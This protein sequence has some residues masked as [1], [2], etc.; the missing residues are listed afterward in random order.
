MPTDWPQCGNDQIGYVGV[1]PNQTKFTHPQPIRQVRQGETNPALLYLYF[2]VVMID[3]ITPAL[4]EVGG[5]PQINLF[6]SGWTTVD[7]GQLESLDF[8]NY[9]CSLSPACVANGLGIILGQYQGL[10]TLQA[11]A[12]PIE[13][14]ESYRESNIFN[15]G[16]SP[17]LLSYVTLAEAENYFATRMHTKYWD[18]ACLQDKLKSLTTATK[19]IDRLAFQG[20]KTS[21]YRMRIREYYVPGD[22]NDPY[23]FPNFNPFGFNLDDQ[24]ANTSCRDG[25]FQN[26]WQ[27]DLMTQPWEQMLEWP[28]DGSKIVP[29]DIKSATCEIAYQ[30]L[31]G[32]D[33]EMA[34]QSL[35]ITYES[36]SNT[37]S[38]FDRRFSSEHL[39]AGINSIVAWRLLKPYLRDCKHI[40][41]CRVS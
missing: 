31:S 19:D 13:V 30:Y 12:A 8:G 24:R 3:N 28:R 11:N 33:V 9:R 22:W 27:K 32:F 38:G 4:N 29:P 41:T 20:V 6:G 2:Y 23:Y 15:Q 39:I 14:I 7:V 37:R 21:E 1:P 5:Q 16:D 40:R 34:N 35:Q 17:K 26:Q 25:N 10:T 36:F 18:K